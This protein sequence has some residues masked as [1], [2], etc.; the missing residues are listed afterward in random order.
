MYLSISN[1]V[2]TSR[3]KEDQRGLP[4]V[5]DFIC[6]FCIVFSTFLYQY[7]SFVPGITVGELLLIAC[8][9][10]IF[11]YTKRQY[12][13]TL[14]ASF[15]LIYLSCL[16]FSVLSFG[17]STFDFVLESRGIVLSR[18][19]RY[20]AYV[21]FISV[22]CFRNNV[23]RYTVKV[24]KVACLVVSFYT[25]VQFL[26]FSFSKIYLPVNI[27][28]IPFSN[29]VT[30]DIAIMVSGVSGYFRGYGFF[31]EPSH[32]VKF[33]LPF[34]AL[35]LIETKKGKVISLCLSGAAILLSTSL[36]GILIMAITFVIAIMFSKKIH[37][38]AKFLLFLSAF[39][40]CLI[41]IGSGYLSG[42][43]DRLQNLISGNLDGSTGFRVFKGFAVFD[44]LPT[45]NKIIGVGM[46]NI[47]NFVKSNGI[48]TPYD[49]LIMDADSI[50]FV[51][52][53]SCLLLEGGLISLI[54]YLPFLFFLFNRA[55]FF[56][57][58]L[59]LLAIES[60]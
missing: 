59:I 52:G 29:G 21:I 17:S 15:L 35:T 46:G 14:I 45:T 42:V 25:I 37:A 28:P 30:S 3:A 7:S 36:Q 60:Y 55:C 33:L 22:L 41:I 13:R 48:T 20:L 10:I 31:T 27:L 1:N 51:S 49:T 44:R 58:S 23:L 12:D 24:Y 9:I 32:L 18:C 54:L 11:A 47:A 40:I 2:I 50:N 8:S 6:S 26:V 19:I 4:A 5:L 57:I 16:F 38:F 53:I 43:M 39:V 56:C 34:V